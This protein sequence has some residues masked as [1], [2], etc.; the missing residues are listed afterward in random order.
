MI[1][2]RVCQRFKKVV[3][4]SNSKRVKVMFNSGKQ[5]IKCY[6]STISDS[7]RS[8]GFAHNY[9][10]FT[11]YDCLG[12]DLDNTLARYKVGAMIEMEYDIL[13]NFLVD[14]K[15]YSAKHLLKPLDHNFIIKGLIVDDEN[16]NLLR[17]SGDGTIIQATHGTKILTQQEVKSYYPNLRWR[18][19]DLFAEDPLQTWNGPYSEKM[20]TLLDYYD[21]I[22]SLIFARA[23]NSIDEDNSDRKLYNIWPDL[24]A[25]LQDMFTREHFQNEKG[26]YFA[27]IK[28]NPHT[29]Y[30]K[31]SNHLIRWLNDL[32]AKGKILFL[33]TGSY[34]D[35]ATHTA[36]HTI[37][38]N[39][40]DMFDIV[41]SYAKK[42][43]FFTDHKDFISLDGFKEGEAL[44]IDDLKLGGIYTQGNW[45]D[46]KTFLE[47]HSKLSN[48]RF[49]YIGDNLV[50]DIYTPH[51]YAGCDT[52]TVCEELEAEGVYGHEKW[53][54]DEQFL[55]S[56]V[57]GSYFKSKDTGQMTNWYDIMKKH[58]KFFV[59]SLEYVATFPVDHQFKI[60]IY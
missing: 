57:W 36:S 48:P 21:V 40:R 23:V 22:V 46:L 19:T 11:D 25:A 33:I 49:L 4:I 16:G 39:W 26:K 7:T 2:T 15:G 3:N 31:C 47:T 34:V 30:Y 56:T 38:E 59:P 12:F 55:C 28:A 35:F 43:G 20:R 51:V 14:N 8:K 60:D 5:E 42:P 54:P 50:Q 27:E 58:S 1:A 24:L 53:H 13:A 10:R 18:A 6:S 41:I 37:G 29:Y 45:N 9:F 44:K 32:K 52:V 17:I